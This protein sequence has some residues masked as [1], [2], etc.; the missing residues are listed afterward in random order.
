MMPRR[1]LLVLAVPLALAT[2]A[3][4]QDDIRLEKLLRLDLAVRKPEEQS[5]TDKT[6]FV[7]VDVHHDRAGR[8]RFYVSEG[9]QQLAVSAVGTGDAK[10]TEAKWLHRMT[11][12]VRTSEEND[13][14]DKTRQLGVEVYRELATGNLIYVSDAGAFAVVSPKKAPQEAKNQ[15][16]R[17]LE[18]LPAKV[19][20]AS[21]TFAREALRC[22]FEIYFD[23]N[24]R[25]LILAGENGALGVLPGGQP[26]ARKAPEPL[27][28]THALDLQARLPGTKDFDRKTPI[29]RVEVYEIVCRNAWL[30]LTESLHVA[31]IPGEGPGEPIPAKAP[32]W[33][34]RLHPAGKD[35]ALWSA[36]SFSNPNSEHRVFI[37][38]RGAL[39]VLPP[40]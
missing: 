37:T 23:E 7:G 1:W 32:L 2:V 25:C 31:V 27:E 8:Q 40:K 16:P 38:S 17:W 15:K 13:F 30:Y 36:E 19:R 33:T 10:Q 26:R 3:F 18:R 22:N 24:T 4:A 14:T 39:A 6:R 20:R 34:G 29:F 12:P 9:G 35:A 28:W 21:E 11:L 5:V